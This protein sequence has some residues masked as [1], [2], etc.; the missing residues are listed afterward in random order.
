MTEY[1]CKRGRLRLQG[2]LDL[3]RT[4]GGGSLK[5]SH[6]MENVHA[7]ENAS[8]MLKH[9]SHPKAS[10]YTGMKN[11]DLQ[12]PFYLFIFFKTR[13]LCIALAVLELTL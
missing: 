13:F 7:M 9:I 3:F 2:H 6:A 11:K 10:K 1:E 12:Q 8:R 4:T 5:R